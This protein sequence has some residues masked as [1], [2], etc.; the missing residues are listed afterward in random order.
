MARTVVRTFKDSILVA[1]AVFVVKPCHALMASQRIST[2]ATARDRRDSEQRVSLQATRCPYCT[3][4]L[5]SALLR[6]EPAYEEADPF[7][8]G[9]HSASA[10][11]SPFALPDT[12]TCVATGGGW[13]PR[14][15]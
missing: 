11:N 7:E 4:Q 13:L 5:A 3:A 15:S 10:F 1:T 6:V 12:L 8:Q 9:A 14:M 2:P